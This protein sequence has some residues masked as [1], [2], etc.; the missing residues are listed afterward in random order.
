MPA[1]KG[2][3]KTITPR[4]RASSRRTSGQVCFARG[5]F[6]EPI[7]M[8]FYRE[9]NTVRNIGPSAQRSFVLSQSIIED[10][11][12]SISGGQ[13]KLV[14]TPRG[15]SLVGAWSFESPSSCSST[16]AMGR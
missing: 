9:W 15:S 12:E 16:P 7:D 13:E 6:D 14:G 11:V 3:R 4:A 10:T 2:E 8:A 5:L 1:K